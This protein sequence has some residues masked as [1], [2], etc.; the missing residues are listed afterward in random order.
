M[1]TKTRTIHEVV[2]ALRLALKQTQQ[3]F[4]TTMESAI[5]TVVRYEHAARPNAQQLSKM[6]SIARAHDLEAIAAELQLHLN[7]LLGPAFPVTPD[8]LERMCIQI[9][10]RINQNPKRREAFFK[11]SAR[12]IEQLRAED[13]LRK[14]RADELF[15][16]FDAYAAQQAKGDK[17]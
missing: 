8:P 13:Q 12:E 3:E 14:D 17:R 9:A 10:R 4:A 15:A 5:S 7:V 2:R 11:W 6:L 1:M 16:A